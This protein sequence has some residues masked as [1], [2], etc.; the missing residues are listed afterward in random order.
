[1]DRLS[2]EDYTY[3]TYGRETGTA[4]SY[5]MAIRI[6]ERLFS[7]E[8]VF[9]LNGKKLTELDDIHLLQKITEFVVNEEK[10]FKSNDKGIFKYGLKKQSSYPRGGFCSAAMKHLQRYRAYDLKEIEADKITEQSSDGKLVSE[11]LIKNFDLTKKGI[12]QESI[13]KIRLG[14]AYFRKMILSIYAEK[15]C[16]SGLDIPQ[17]LR[18]SH[19]IP[20]AVDKDNRMNP[21]NG[22]CL[23]GTYDLAFDQHL[24]SFDEQYRLI[25]GKEISEHFSSDVVQNYFI[26][27]EGKKMILPSKYLPSQSF[28]QTHRESLR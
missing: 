11:N 6:I 19:I 12:N 18:A 16:I 20:W 10:N 1:M 27:K 26:K 2:F 5:L 3:L 23:S 7:I 14:Q 4:N 17:L 15:C 22:L 28:L 24:I 21:E 25:V 9:G 8:D 13:T